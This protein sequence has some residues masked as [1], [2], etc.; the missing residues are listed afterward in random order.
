MSRIGKLFFSAVVCLTFSVGAA[1]AGFTVE[2]LDNDFPAEIAA[3]A[4]EGKQLV[5][6][7]HQASCPYC[8]KMRARV[9]PDPKVDA[10]FTK[11][12]I[13]IES[14]IRG[15]LEMVTP[16]GKETTE[17]V[18]ARKIRVRATPVFIFYD[19]Q[20]KDVLRT[21]GYLDPQ[22]FL[23]AGKYVVDQV[24]KNDKSLYR[25]IQEQSATPR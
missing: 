10:Y 20:G 22:N 1:S 4:E 24:Y 5:I 23:L 25:Y 19:K 7:F 14:N 18:F 11:N 15:D 3:A 12:F 13:M 9:H 17:K 2:S 21:T 6:F 8:D 16:D